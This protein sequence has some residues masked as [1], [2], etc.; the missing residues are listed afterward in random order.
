MAQQHQLVKAHFLE[1]FAQLTNQLDPAVVADVRNNLV[2]IEQALADLQRAL[3]HDP[4]N[5]RLNELL[6]ET[7]AHERQLI[8]QM[9]SSYFTI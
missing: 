7:Y 4:G 3:M 5:P 6:I 9:K 8:E 2:V 1:E